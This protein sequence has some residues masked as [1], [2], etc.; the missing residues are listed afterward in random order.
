LNIK[1]CSLKFS[2][3]IKTYEQLLEHI[4]NIDIDCINFDLCGLNLKSIYLLSEYLC[5]YGKFQMDVIDLRLTEIFSE[6]ERM[7]NEN[8]L[9]PNDFSDIMEYIFNIVFEE[10]TDIN[11]KD[12]EDEQNIEQLYSEYEKK[13]FMDY[14]DGMKEKLTEKYYKE[15]L[16]LNDSYGNYLGSKD[17][18]VN[19]EGLLLEK[20][21]KDNDKIN[22]E[23]NLIL[24]KSFSFNDSINN[25]II[26]KVH[27]ANRLFISSSQKKFISESSLYNYTYPIKRILIMERNSFKFFKNPFAYFNQPK[28]SEEQSIFIDTHVLKKIFHKIGNDY[29]FNKSNINYASNRLFKRSVNQKKIKVTFY[30]K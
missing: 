20:Y 13:S 10:K 24:Y 7:I 19:L 14:S 9:N 21:F 18:M 12:N 28:L 16:N 2:K 4:N 26:N 6:V 30:D 17:S 3:N 29:F 27:K 11:N 22:Q 1:L 25:K 8:K 15:K 5:Y 23:N